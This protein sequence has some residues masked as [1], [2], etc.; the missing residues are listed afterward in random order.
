VV[1]VVVM[2]ILYY[3]YTV[4]SVSIIIMYKFNDVY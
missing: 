2:I 1:V 3:R 4:L